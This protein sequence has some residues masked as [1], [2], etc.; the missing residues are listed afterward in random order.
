LVETYGLFLG[1]GLGSIPALF[2]GIII[3]FIWPLL[4]AVAFFLFEA[5]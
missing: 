4:A 3:G 1:G 5:R 2:L